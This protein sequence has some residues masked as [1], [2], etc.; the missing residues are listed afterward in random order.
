MPSEDEGP[1]IEN[2]GMRFAEEVDQLA[3]LLEKML[4]FSPEERIRIIE[5]YTILNP[6]TL[7]RQRSRFRKEIMLEGNM[8]K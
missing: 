7:S 8:C 3:D 6:P 4:K 1:M 5:A 2:L